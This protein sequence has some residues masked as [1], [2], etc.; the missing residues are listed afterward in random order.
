MRKEGGNTMR[1]RDS[2]FMDAVMNEMFGITNDDRK[3]RYEKFLEENHLPANTK[4]EE[5]PYYMT[6]HLESIGIM[7]GEF[8]QEDADKRVEEKQSSGRFEELQNSY[9]VDENGSLVGPH[10]ENQDNGYN[11]DEF[12]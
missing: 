11:F 8:L 3:E 10:G 2:L 6:K 4:Y 1:S 7:D 9:S 5:L 12:D